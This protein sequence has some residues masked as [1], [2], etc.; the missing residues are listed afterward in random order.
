MPAAKS[1]TVDRYEYGWLLSSLNGAAR[2]ADTLGLQHGRLDA[3]L[4]LAEGPRSVGLDDW[5]DEAF[6][7][8]LRHAVATANREPL[9]PLS[10]VLTRHLLLQALRNRL[11][12]RDYLKR[13][14][15]IQDVPVQ[16]PIFVLG[17]PRTGTTLIQNL[18]A[19]HPSRR[20][21]QFWE[22]ARPTP[23]VADPK[24][25]TAKR[26]AGAKRELQV[27]Y[28]VAPE[29]AE[30][31]AIA[32]D[33]MEECW[34]LFAPAF[35]VLN[36]DLSS[37]FADYGQWLLDQDMR[38]PYAEYRVYLQALLHQRPTETLVL[39]CPEHLWF[40]DA[41]FD[42]FPDAGVVWTHRSPFASIGS[43]SSMTS[44]AWRML[45]GAVDPHEVGEHIS[46]RFQTGLARAMEVRARVGEDRFF[47]VHFRQLVDDPATVL[48]G[49]TEKFDLPQS[50]DADVQAY[51]ATSRADDRGRHNYDASVFGLNSAQIDDRF[52]QYIERFSLQSRR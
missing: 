38:G 16:R 18:L 27:A 36:W 12:F 9:T 40:L 34:P 20:G 21:L 6:I 51:L 50:D 10:R 39:K 41:L 11:Q 4:I 35:A 24:R 37:G 13:T 47:D 48:R 43:Y 3:D 1:P 46:D 29:M 5:G 7:P 26:M 33:T 14:S 49:I 8:R 45:Y 22:L 17:F 42:V 23:L 32:Y 2:V 15:A 19:L 28:M 30:M 44:L 25:D 31:H 52:S